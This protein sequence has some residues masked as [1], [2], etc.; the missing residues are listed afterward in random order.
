MA[1][2]DAALIEATVVHVGESACEPV[3]VRLP[4][5]STLLDAVIAAGL[6]SRDPQQPLRLP[7][8]GVFNRPRPADTLLRAGDRVEIYAPLLIDPKQARRVRAAV[9]RRRHG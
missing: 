7:D 3:A 1:E 4:A 5:G 2:P 9:R 6:W 8:L